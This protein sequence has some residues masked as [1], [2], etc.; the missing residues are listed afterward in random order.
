MGC[1][2]DTHSRY[3]RPEPL[4]LPEPKPVGYTPT[5]IYVAIIVCGALLAITAPID[6][7]ALPSLAVGFGM[8]G[9]GGGLLCRRILRMDE[10]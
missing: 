4:P 5:I 9:L 8:M 1:Q 2:W 3:I 7:D 6:R 10:S